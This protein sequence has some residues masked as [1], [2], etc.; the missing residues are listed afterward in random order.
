MSRIIKANTLNNNEYA[1]ISVAITKADLEPNSV[2][3]KMTGA[4]ILMNR[5]NV[6]KATNTVKSATNGGKQ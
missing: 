1:T 6:L 2:V 5:V 4:A 3:I